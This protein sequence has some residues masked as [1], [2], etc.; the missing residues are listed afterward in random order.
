MTSSF[1]LKPTNWVR[2]KEKCRLARKIRS[3]TTGLNLIS[4][5]SVGLLNAVAETPETKSLS[6]V[7]LVQ[8]ENSMETFFAKYVYTRPA[9]TKYLSTEKVRQT[10]TANVKSS[11]YKNLLGRDR[12]ESNRNGGKFVNNDQQIFNFARDDLSKNASTQ[13]PAILLRRIGSYIES[14]GVISCGKEVGTCWLVKDLFI[15]TNY[16]VY[17]DFIK[18]RIER[19]NPN[20]PITVS[21]D[22]FDRQSLQH[23]QTV[24]VDEEE[25][26]EIQSSHLDYIFLRLK[27]NEALT[28]RA[29]LGPIVRNHRL[30]EGLVTIIGHPA[31]RE[32]LEE[33]CVVVSNHSWRT[34]VEQRHEKFRQMNPGHL[35]ASPGLH[36]ANER[37]L[38]STERKERL[39]YDT[40]LFSGAS[41]SPVFDLNV[42]IVAIHTQGY[43]LDVKGG[44]FS[45]MEF[46]IQF[47]AICEDLRV[48]YGLEK[49][50]DLFPNYNLGSKEERMDTM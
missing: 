34:R 48:E 44:N 20:L 50:E 12:S 5:F 19:K 11:A 37:L 16:H 7:D 49:L 35:Q 14:I 9:S 10:M 8:L 39:P 46:G 3:W 17:E 2:T 18:E 24:E 36:L 38:Q 29:R 15:I 25:E 6:K 27:E 28:G 41:G 23:V 40:S 43:V 42:N 45:L 22:F 21:F 26:P 1:R 30:Q 31:G 33:T 4:I 47:A 13:K 32:M